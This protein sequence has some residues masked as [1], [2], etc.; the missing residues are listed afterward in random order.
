MLP[1]LIDWCW[2]PYWLFSKSCK[3]TKWKVSFCLCPG[4]FFIFYNVQWR[5]RCFN[6]GLYEVVKRQI[7]YLLL[8]VYSYEKQANPI[9]E[10]SLACLQASFEGFLFHLCSSPLAVTLRIN[11]LLSYCLPGTLS[12][13]AVHN[14]PPPSSSPA[15]PHSLP[16]T[17]THSVSLGLQKA[18]A[19][20]WQIFPKKQFY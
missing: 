11:L 5:G 12:H 14:R 18:T 10:Q 9:P 13:S 15:H 6:T 2:E 7:L 16:H 19:Q 3:I 4:P 8:A 20:T 1:I 17:H